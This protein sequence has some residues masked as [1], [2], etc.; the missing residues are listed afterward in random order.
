M[1]SIDQV[2]RAHDDPV[3]ALGR[4]TGFS[5]DAIEAMRRSMARGGGR[6]AQ[7]DHPEFGGAG[8]WMQGGLLMIGDSSNHELRRR[9]D[10]LCEAL[11]RSVAGGSARES[12]VGAVGG[13]WQSQTT[14]GGDGSGGD[15]GQRPG[16]WLA[17]PTWYPASLGTPDTS[18]SQNDLRYAWFASKRRLV[19][20]R[21][22]VVT[23]YDTGDHRIAG[24]SQ[25]QGAGQKLSFA[26]QHGDIDLDRLPVL[27]GERG[28]RRDDGRVER[29]PM[30]TR[31]SST[32][33]AVDPFTALEKLADLHARGILDADEFASK[34]SELLK[35]I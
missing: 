17:Q 27:G 2:N 30:A 32:Q 19:V 8:Q 9:I 12:G 29:E 25:Q 23:L 22:G 28:E 13:Q 24:V 1:T 11:S 7:F 35:R 16:Q 34:K 15:V 20:D 26:S 21:R 33:P 10:G 31:P 18:G 6:M 3:D 14:G 4:D 5:H